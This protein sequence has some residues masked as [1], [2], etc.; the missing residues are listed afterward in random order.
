MPEGAKAHMHWGL[1]SFL[2]GLLAGAPG[3]LLATLALC[4]MMM[5]LPEMICFHG[6]DSKYHK[7]PISS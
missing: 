5:L 2:Q 3:A 7:K 4:H 1:F 6:R